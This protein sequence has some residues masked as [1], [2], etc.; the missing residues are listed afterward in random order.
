MTLGS[1]FCC[2]PGHNL[3][4]NPTDNKFG[5]NLSKVSTKSRGSLIAIFQVFFCRSLPVLALVLALT[6]FFSKNE[7]FKEFMTTY[8]ATQVQFSTPAPAPALFHKPQKQ[9]LKAFFPEIYFNNPHI[10]CYKFYQYYKNHF[11]VAKTK[12][13]NSILF[14]ILFFHGPIRLKWIQHKL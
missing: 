4:A 13:P 14:V 11:D 6:C 8:W 7:L 3:S 10:E 1:L 2:N 12:K 5:G 9:L